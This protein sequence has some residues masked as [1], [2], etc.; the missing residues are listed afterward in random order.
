MEI[1]KK[2]GIKYC[3]GCNPAYERVKMVEWLQSRLKDQI[4][5]SRYNQ[6]GLDALVLVNGC[7]RSCATENLNHKEVPCYSTVGEK[8]FGT[9]IDWLTALNE[10]LNFN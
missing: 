8:D 9:L 2:I 10:T 7:P 5:L 1:K 3:G 4:L 6:P